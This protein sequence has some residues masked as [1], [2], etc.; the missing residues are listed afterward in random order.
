MKKIIA[1]LLLVV[2]VLTSCGKAAPTLQPPVV[3]TVSR[4]PQLAGQTPAVEERLALDAPMDLVFDR[5]MDPAS[6]GSA[7]TLTDADGNKVAGTVS[8]PDARTL[9]FTPTE[10]LD[11]ASKY[12][13]AV[14]T[15]AKDADGAALTEA[16][17]AEFQTVESL[18]VG[19]VFPA[20]DAEDVD[21]ASTITVIFNRP[22]VP[23]TVAEEQSQLPQPLTIQPEVKGTGEW[24][25][26]SVYVFQPEK[27]LGSGVSY[28]VSVDAGL[29]DT[30][31]MSLGESYVWKFVTRARAST[32]S[33]SSTARPTRRWTSRTSCSTRR[34]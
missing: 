9:R 28:M 17:R 16:L 6:T 12:V 34:S 3:P 24:V 30:L 33:R 10:T 1:S 18:E 7:F 23:M 13:A 32:R 20:P 26:S 31:G 11:P 5:P 15:S 29:K 21:L 27:L 4:A 19:Q 25:S 14:S 22:I 2:F 8:W